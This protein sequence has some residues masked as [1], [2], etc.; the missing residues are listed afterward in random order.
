MDYGIASQEDLPKLA[1]LRWDFRVEEDETPAVSQT[2]FIQSCTDFLERGFEAGNWA[3]WVAKEEGEIVSHV[4]INTIRPVPRPCNL[5]DRYGYMTNVYTRPEY[6][7][8]GIGTELMRRA[9]QWAA[10][11]GLE[12]VIVSPSEESLPFYRRAGFSEETDFMQLRLKE[13]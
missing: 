11:E 12:L 2:T 1:R 6:R 8:K 3:Y 9:M 13:Y 4:F 5:D 10:E 7:N